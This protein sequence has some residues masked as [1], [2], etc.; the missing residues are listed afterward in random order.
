M[1]IYVCAPDGFFS[2]P[3]SL[4]FQEKIRSAFLKNLREF[5]G[6]LDNSDIEFWKSRTNF[7]D[8]YV[9]GDAA[10]K[11]S[12]SARKIQ[13]VIENC[14]ADAFGS[15]EEFDSMNIEPHINFK[16]GHHKINPDFHPDMLKPDKEQE[17]VSYV[18]PDKAAAPQ[19]QESRR[20]D[21]ELKEFDY[22]YL[23]R[24]F[25]AEEPRYSFGRVILP[26]SV[27]TQIKEALAI[28]KV[29]AKVFDEWGLR[30]IMPFATCAMSFYGPPGTGKSMAA[31][32]IADHLGKKII[33]AAY[34]DI[35]SKYKG[36]GQKMV[37]ALFLA[38]EK[39]NAVLFIDESEWAKE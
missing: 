28:I 24:N 2:H 22:E 26:A 13:D 12:S 10:N 19:A 37:K 7:I 16:L 39:Q 35:T 9:M 8:V 30:N 21:D 33:R 36:Q 29:E 1:K 15:L 3:K 11:N 5:Y 17:K 18:A 14:I 32:A 38:A 25:Q 20:D 34:A 4:I 27:M 31:E 23:S 6:R